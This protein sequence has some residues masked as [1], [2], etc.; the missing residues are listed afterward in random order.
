[1]HASLARPRKPAA[2]TPLPLLDERGARVIVG[3]LPGAPVAPIAPSATSLF[4]P[5]GAC[6]ASPDGPLFVCD[7]GHH[8]LLIWQHAPAADGA[9]ADFVIGQPGFAA[10]GRAM[11]NMPTGVDYAE[12][13]L[14]VA[15]AW[16][17]HVLLWH[18]VPRE[19]DQAPDVVLSGDLFW[20]FGVKFHDGGLYV[21]DTGNRRVLAWDR[22]PETSCPADRIVREGLRWPHAIAFPAGRMF[23]ADAGEMSD[24]LNMPYGATVAGGLLVIADTANSRLVGIGASEERY[25]AGEESWGPAR[26][27]SLCWPYGVAG[28]GRTLVV[29]DT[30]NNRV[31]LWDLA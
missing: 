22:V 21:A 18:G 30:G 3:S 31:L 29:A 4:A 2:H 1:M 12:G 19:R 5:R 17:Q 13:I 11:L 23:V 27:D 14:A 25:V 16:N 9:P 10:E 6:L 15:D 28:C 24:E 26:R 8:R 7:T 20:P